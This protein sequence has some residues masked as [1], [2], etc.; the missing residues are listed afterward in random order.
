MRIA[1]EEHWILP[2][3]DSALRR[4]PADRSDP[5]LALNDHGGAR[6]KL[7]D[8]SGRRLADMDAL[9]ID[10]QILSLAPP[11]AGPLDQDEAIALSRAANDRAAAAAAE[12]PDRFR[13]LAT[14]PMSAPRAVAAELHR[15]VGVGAVGA[16]VYGRTGDTALDDPGTEPLFEAAERLHVPLFVHPQIPPQSV[17]QA[18]Y[19]GFSP[20]VELALASFA[21][22][23][24]VE[25]G[26]AVLRMIAAGVFDRHPG[27]QVVLGHWGELLLLWRERARS[28]G[29]IA[30][31]ERSVDQIIAENLHVTSSGMLDAEVLRHVLTITS[32]DR[33]MLSIDYPFQ[34]PGAD[35]LDEFLSDF[36]VVDR[37]AFGATNAQW[38]FRIPP[39]A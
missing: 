38:L 25:A 21:W 35:E 31:L 17:R 2:E 4:L 28:V 19:A 1:I 22:G 26:T 3:L 8:L 18:E 11:G 5:S 20:D 12:H 30:R 37:A 13:F 29:R 14:L 36:S 7:L 23:W 6:E 32:I 16:M 27:L 24:H 39:S 34:Q 9:G 10:L 15:A 33:L